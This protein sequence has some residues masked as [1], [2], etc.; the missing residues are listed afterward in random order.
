MGRS[1]RA[2]GL[3]N[4]SNF[5]FSLIATNMLNHREFLDAANGTLCLCTPSTWGVLNSQLK[6]PRQ[7]EFGGRFTF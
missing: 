3:Q 4:R 6:P 5:E 7:M 1:R 2:S